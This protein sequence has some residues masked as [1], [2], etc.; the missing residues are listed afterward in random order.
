MWPS[1][2]AVFVVEVCETHNDENY[3]LFLTTNIPTYA[4]KVLKKQMLSYY[5]QV[6]D[7]MLSFYG[8]HI[9]TLK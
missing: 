5:M 2:D 6:V 3:F 1:A 7:Q 4:A 9:Y 8:I